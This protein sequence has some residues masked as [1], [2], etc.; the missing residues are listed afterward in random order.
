ML[1]NELIVASVAVVEADND[2]VVA[3]IGDGNDVNGIE[4]V[5]VTAF[6]VVTAATTAAILASNVCSCCVC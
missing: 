5:V 2:D 3:V 1:A 6:D 4:E